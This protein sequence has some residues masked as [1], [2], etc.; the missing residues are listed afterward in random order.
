[1][2]DDHNKSFLRGGMERLH[3]DCISGSHFRSPRY[4]MFH[5]SY[6]PSVGG[7]VER[8][9]VDSADVPLQSVLIDDC[10]GGSKP[11]PHRAIP[12]SQHPPTEEELARREA[13]K[14]KEALREREARE[15]EEEDEGKVQAELE[16]MVAKR[17]RMRG[18]A[19]NLGAGGG[20]VI[21]E[22]CTPGAAGD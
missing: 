8:L 10:G 9:P 1:M 15:A 17:D 20:D 21:E 6:I 14:A 7:M 16:E 22:I 4:E 5:D 13:K 12:L 11:I 2:L 19:K 3:S 18:W